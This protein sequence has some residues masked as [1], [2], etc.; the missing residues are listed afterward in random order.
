[1]LPISLWNLT[2]T[3]VALVRQ[4]SPWHAMSRDAIAFA[5]LL[6]DA[7]AY[8]VAAGAGN[9]APQYEYGGTTCLDVLHP[10]LGDDTCPRT[11]LPR[12]LGA[13]VAANAQQCGA[14]CVVPSCKPAN[15]GIWS[16]HRSESVAYTRH[17]ACPDDARFVQLNADVYI[18]FD[19]RAFA[20]PRTSEN[21]GN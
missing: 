11:G 18:G 17:P 6:D 3:P 21:A 4:A 10:L 2:S 14:R 16:A 9:D 15:V 12:N 5:W 13:A 20:T 1:M 7:S 8:L 19:A